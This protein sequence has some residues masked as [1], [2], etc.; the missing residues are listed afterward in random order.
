MYSFRGIPHDWFTSY[1][2]N[3]MQ[4][5]QVGNEKSNLLEMS[6]GVPQGSTSGSLLCLIYVNDIA[7]SSTGLSFRLFA[8][9]S[10]IF[11]SSNGIT[12]IA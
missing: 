8:D 3:R 11:Y 9:D 7:N 6:C 5:V 12:D 10:N 2:S 4:F 1:L